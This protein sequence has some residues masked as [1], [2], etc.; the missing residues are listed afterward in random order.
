MAT[1]EFLENRV[2]GKQ[3][4]LEK[5]EKKMERILKA[6]ATNWEV[7]PYWYNEGD[8]RITEKEIASC[9]VSL[10][11]YKM[12]LA[13]QIEKDNSRDIKPILEFLD[14]WKQRVFDAYV[15]AFPRYI[16][17]RDDWYAVSKAHADWSNSQGYTMRRDNREEYN[18]IEREYK[19]ARN[20]YQSTWSFITP[21]VEIDTLN[22]EKLNKDLAIEANAKYDFI[23]ERTNA[24]VG[25]ITDA[26]NLKVGAKGDLNGY[27]IG[28][29]GK[30]KVQ[31]IGA[32]GY[33]IQIFH[34][35]TLITPIK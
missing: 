35:R 32:G 25:Q 29:R 21:Y 4:E 11:D 10:E 30:A 28:T 16:K 8:L 24:I 5:L 27:I 17:A 7:N 9:K 19:E 2:S 34:Y 26:S 20:R 22:T 23:V 18:R 15:E 33:N 14:L 3:K 6:Q 12:K 31:T 13:A 1:R